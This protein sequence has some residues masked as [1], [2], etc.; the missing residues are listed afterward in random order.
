MGFYHFDQIAGWTAAE[1]AWVDRNIE[2]FK[3]R[4]TRDDW[5]AQA[6]MLASGDDTEFASRVKKSD[7]NDT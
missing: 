3:G 5:V 7:V 1:I 4:A 2:G 6:R